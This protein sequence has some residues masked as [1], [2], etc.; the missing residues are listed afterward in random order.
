MDLDNSQTEQLALNAI[1][2]FADACTLPNLTPSCPFYVEENGIPSCK[3]QCRQVAYDMGAKV[4]PV[5]EHRIGG[6]V[7]KG[8]ELPGDVVGGINDFD[9]GREFMAQRHLPPSGQTLTS[10]LVGLESHFIRAV[11][12]S[13]SSRK[14]INDLWEELNRRNFPI[15]LTAS[16]GMSGALADTVLALISLPTLR[17]YGYLVPASQAVESVVENQWIAFA[18]ES[19]GRFLEQTRSKSARQRRRVLMIP[20]ALQSSEL[21]GQEILNI[22]RKDEFLSYIFHPD[23]FVRVHHWFS[24]I[25]LQGPEV[26]LTRIVPNV[27]LFSSLEKITQS[28]EYGRWLWDR[29]SITRLD[30]WALSSLKHEWNWLRNGVDL[31]IDR[32]F[33]NE[34]ETEVRRVTDTYFE[35][36]LSVKPIQRSATF[37]TSSFTEAAVEKLREG[38]PREAA[39]IFAGLTEILPSSGEAWNNLGFCRMAFDMDGALKAFARS[40]QFSRNYGSIRIANHMLALHL[41]G[42][43][44]EAISLSKLQIPEEQSANAWA[45]EISSMPNCPKLIEIEDCKKYLF[46]VIDYVKRE[47]SSG[48]PTP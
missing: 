12:G 30:Q 45:W 48:L 38:N 24:K 14:L 28:D 20:K 42:R 4:R 43:T 13:G 37:Q 31:G 5:V 21:N 7:M 2:A 29:L 26:A 39:D 8:R 35:K 3:E 6:L 22:S 17:K 25:L 23:F 10:L 36:L 32:R 11:L 9:A 44:K 1:V 34:R 18:N 47:G 40:A 19:L 16:S 41:G 15:A 33:L 46:D 27:S